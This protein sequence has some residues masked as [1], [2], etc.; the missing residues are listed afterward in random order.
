MDP[1]LRKKLKAYGAGFEHVLQDKFLEDTPTKFAKG[2]RMDLMDKGDLVEEIM[3]QGGCVIR[4]LPFERK[5]YMVGEAKAPFYAALRKKAA[6]L[7][8]KGARS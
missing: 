3:R 7:K 2:E 5:M 1:E 6:A 8:K 4:R